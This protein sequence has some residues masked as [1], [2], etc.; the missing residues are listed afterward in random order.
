MNKK[1]FL[2]ELGICLAILEE[3]EQQDILAEYSQHIDMKIEKGLSEEEA[4]RDFGNIRELAGEILEAYHVNPDYKT[5]GIHGRKVD[6]KKAV[7]TGQHMCRSATS[8]LK[9][10]VKAVRQFGE[11]C[12]DRI[13]R[14]SKRLWLFLSKPWKHRDGMRFWRRRD[15]R[16]LVEG[17]EF[18]EDAVFTEGSETVRLTQVSESGQRR[19]RRAYGSDRRAFGEGEHALAGIRTYPGRVCRFVGGLMVGCFR[20]CLQVAVWC[21][22]WGWNV[23]MIMLALFSGIFTLCA[24]FGFGAAVIWLAQGYPLA[25][26]SLIGLGTILCGGS[27]T[28]LCI[29][30]MR[31]NRRGDKRRTRESDRQQESGQDMEQETPVQEEFDEEVQHA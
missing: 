10:A 8:I 27:F 23:C 26:I 22:R 15:S 20:L 16:P 4:I 17:A 7:E 21:I 29:S 25:G 13:K 30:L 12:I 5:A 14:G 1:E 6:G 18:T 3:K 2:Q 19:T 24:L 31:I 28:Y 11:A 9:R